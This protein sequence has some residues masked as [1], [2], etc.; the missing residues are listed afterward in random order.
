MSISDYPPHAIVEVEPTCDLLKQNQRNR[1]VIAA[2]PIVAAPPDLQHDVWRLW[3]CYQHLF[4]SPLPLAGLIRCWVDLHGLTVPDARA[5]LYSM[6]A[7]EA[8]GSF[9]FAS[10]LTT[11]L[12]SKVAE[13]LKWVAKD[14][15][16]ERRRKEQEALDADAPK[17]ERGDLV[18]MFAERIGMPT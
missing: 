15:A 10:E 12:A 1:E 4:P 5:I 9:K 13:R 3:A 6:L 16:A 7:P 8:V 2:N 14:A 17:V 18:Q 11:Q